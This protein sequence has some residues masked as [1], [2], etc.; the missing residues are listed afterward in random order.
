MPKNLKELFNSISLFFK[1]IFNRPNLNKVIFIFILGFIS[2]AF[3]NNIYDVNVFTD[4]M[5]KISFI[6]YLFFSLFIIIIHE[7]I[8]YFH[9]NIIPSFLFINQIFNIIIK[10]FDFVIRI[11]ISMNKR[12]FF[13]KLEDIKISS[14]IKGIKHLFNRDNDKMYINQYPTPQESINRTKILDSKSL[15]ESSNILEKNDGNGSKKR[16]SRENYKQNRE[17][18]NEEIRL[19]R[20]FADRIRLER[21]RSGTLSE[22]GAQGY[23]NTDASRYESVQLPP[24][25]N[26]YNPNNNN[27]PIFEPEVNLRPIINPS[28]E[29]SNPADYRI[30]LV[31]NNTSYGNQSN[32]NNS[33]SNNQGNNNYT[34]NNTQA[35]NYTNGN[36]NTHNNQD[37]TNSNTDN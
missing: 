5:N 19:R 28:T 36:N 32:N 14:I 7:F 12:I 15:K 31:N 4:Y 20:E 16:L 35:N 30:R 21:L 22:Q 2:R 26:E 3:I 33:T 6:Y 10:I 17:S 27:L 9:I 8:N 23:T 37:E 13:Y 25:V 29:G 34:D 24:V 11:F 1:I 18:R